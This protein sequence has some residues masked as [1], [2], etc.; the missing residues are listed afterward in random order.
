MAD[1]KKKWWERKK[2][3]E[4]K[5][6][7]TEWGMVIGILGIIDGIQFALDWVG[8]PFVATVGTVLNRFIDFAVGLA[9]PTY[10]WLRGVN[11]KSVKTFGSIALTFFLEEIPDVDALPLWVAD[12]AFVMATV[13]AE[14]TIKEKTG[15]DAEK[16]AALA[17]GAP[18][19]TE[20]AK[21]G[22]NEGD[23]AAN[24]EGETENASE[25]GGTSDENEEAASQE[26]EGGEKNEGETERD[27]EEGGGKLEGLTQVPGKPCTTEDGEP[28]V[29][30]ADP[31]NPG[32][33]ICVPTNEGKKKG[34]DK[35]KPPIREE[36]F[37]F[38]GGQKRAEGAQGI[39]SDPLNLRGGADENREKEKESARF[40]SNLL[41]LSLSYGERKRR[42]E[43]GEDETSL[44]E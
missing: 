42:R 17:G 21:A 27:E 31:K 5:I 4:S 6:S 36:G 44:S 12:G 3:T 23:G 15:V 14:E 28:G 13:K 20:S 39:G 38:G 22:P 7:N 29:Y 11:L 25:S 18:A 10:L 9:W 43:A 41:D 26:T 34:G 8:L 35:K 19:E 2:A 37:G 30:Q 33:L 1:A 24:G 32:A 16:A 40:H